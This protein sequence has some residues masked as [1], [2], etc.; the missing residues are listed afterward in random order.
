MRKVPFYSTQFNDCKF[1]AALYLF[2]TKRTSRRSHRVWRDIS[3]HLASSVF[4]NPSFF[5]FYATRINLARHFFLF[6]WSWASN[7]VPISREKL[8]ES[9]D[10]VEA[11]F[12]VRRWVASFIY[13]YETK[14]HDSC[15]DRWIIIFSTVLR[16]SRILKNP[17]NAQ[18]ESTSQLLLFQKKEDF[19]SF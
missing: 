5:E 7:Y 18:V 4:V 15:L 11:S 17:R 16:N 1:L 12:H 6:N 10:C 13:C 9:K 19:H 14:C 3:C 8:T 2:R